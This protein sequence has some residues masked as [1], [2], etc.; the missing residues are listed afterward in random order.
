MDQFN[1]QTDA[2]IYE[3]YEAADGP[4][5]KKKTKLEH[6]TILKKLN[7]QFPDIDINEHE[8]Q[9]FLLVFQELIIFSNLDKKF[10]DS[11]DGITNFA[12]DS[13]ETN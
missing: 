2:K 1:R 10:S 6:H 8:I 4:F 3:N 12:L 5:R 13:S 11:E 7:K 9:K